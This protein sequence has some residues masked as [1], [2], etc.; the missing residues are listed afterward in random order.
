MGQYAFCTYFDH[1]FAD[2]GLVLLESLRRYVPEANLHVLALS[3]EC[4]AFLSESGLDGV[5]VVPLEQLLSR[6]PRLCEIRE[7]RTPTEFIFT[8]TPFIVCETL[9]ALQQGQQVVYLDA[10][11]MFFGSPEEFL[12]KS[13]EFDVVI[14]PHNFSEHMS[15]QLRY[16][17]YNVGWVGFKKSPGGERCARWWADQCLAWCHDRLED[18]K[19]ADQ[20]YLESFKEVADSALTSAPMGLNSAPWNVSGRR[21]RNRAGRVLVDEEPL[22]LYHFAKASRVRPWCLATRIRQQAVVG[23]KG[24]LKHVYRPYAKALDDVTRRYSIPREWIAPGAAKRSGS[25]HRKMTA[26]EN[27]GVLRLA[28]GLLRGNYVA[29]GVP[30]WPGQQRTA[31]TAVEDSQGGD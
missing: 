30:A 25:K 15:S 24:L 17:V 28:A 4:E 14:T 23:A 22:I 2:R 31:R 5:V 7:S 21:F 9:G 16:G 13:A 26:D 19:F 20:K 29:S 8:L 3:S 1:R 27:P 6:E 12:E 11:M 10:D 18:G